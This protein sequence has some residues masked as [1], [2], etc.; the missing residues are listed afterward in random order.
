MV[1]KSRGDVAEAVV[2]SHDRFF[3]RKKSVKHMLL[4][5]QEKMEQ[6]V[7]MFLDKLSSCW[8]I[9]QIQPGFLYERQRLCR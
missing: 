3:S 1:K 9:G 4:A 8:P 5:M 2:Y 7:V 6:C